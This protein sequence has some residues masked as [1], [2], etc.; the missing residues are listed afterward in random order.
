[1]QLNQELTRP[2][3]HDRFAELRQKSVDALNTALA[4]RPAPARGN[5]AAYRKPPPPQLRNLT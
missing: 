3:R 1:M 2:S 4:Y 5:S